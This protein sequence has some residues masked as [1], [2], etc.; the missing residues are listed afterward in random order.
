VALDESYT[1][2]NAHAADA[3]GKPRLIKIGLG[4]VETLLQCWHLYS[5]VIIGCTLKKIVRDVEANV[6]ASQHGQR[7]Q[8][9]R[10]R[11]K[12]KPQA[13]RHSVISSRLRLTRVCL[14]RLA[15]SGEATQPGWR[16]W[17]V[18][19]HISDS[20]QNTQFPKLENVVA[21]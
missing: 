16:R 6:A 7:N 19:G 14:S 9:R 5:T 1:T 12:V 2:R 18:A 10:D 21:R 13:P 11:L 15:S 17:S 4:S 3:N 20:A 8:D